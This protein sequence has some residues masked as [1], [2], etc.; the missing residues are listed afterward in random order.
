MLLEKA[1]FGRARDVLAAEDPDGRFALIPA[2]F[3]RQARCAHISA[4]K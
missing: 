2:Q 1:E 3:F 4:A